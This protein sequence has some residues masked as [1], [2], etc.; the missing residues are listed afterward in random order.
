MWPESFFI[1]IASFA[2]KFTTIAEISNFPRSYFVFRLLD[3]FR[4]RKNFLKLQLAME[5]RDYHFAF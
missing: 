4:L 5:A 1:S 3:P 2:K